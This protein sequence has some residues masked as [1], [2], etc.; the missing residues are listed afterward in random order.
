MQR[1]FGLPLSTLATALLVVL[2]AVLGVVAVLA[3]RNLVFARLAMR[4]V[5]RRRGRSALIVT[6]L[7]LATTIIAAALSTGD[8]VSHAVRSSVLTSLGSTDEM[9]SAKGAKPKAVL[10]FGQ[11]TGVG[12]FDT[13]VAAH[14]RRGLRD[15]SLVDGVAPAI[16][17]P[18]S[19]QDLTSRQTEPTVT[20]FASDPASLQGFGAIRGLDGTAVSLADLRANEVF[21]NARS[22]TKFGAR[23]GDRLTVFAA[24]T[25][26]DATVRAVVRYH[27]AGTDGPAVLM[28]LARAQEIFGQGGR[29]NHVLISNRGDEVSG[30]ANTDAVRALVRPLIARSGLEVDPTKQDGLDAADAQGAAFLSLFT[31]FGTFS[32]SA[33]ILLIFLIFVMLAA[34]RRTEM[35]IARAVGTRRGHLVE[36]FVFEGLAYDLAAAAVGAAL[37]LAVAYAMVTAID[38]ALAATSSIELSFSVVP[39]SVVIAYTLGVVLTLAVVAVSAWRVS[40]LNIVA[41]VRNLPAV[42]LARGGRR[43]RRGGIALAALG[44]IFTMAGVSGKQATPLMLGLSLVVIGCASIAR[45]F[46]VSTRAAYTTAGITVVTLMLLPFHYYGSLVPG[47]QMDFS[48]WIVAGLLV[49]LGAVWV[50]SYNDTIVLGGLVTVLGR[51]RRLAPILKTSVAY[52]LRERFR[53]GAILAMFTLVVFTLV[54]GAT[55][56]NAFS[57][58]GNDTVEFGGGFDVQAMV[59]PVNPITDMRAAIASSPALRASD[60]PVIGAQSYLPVEARQDGDSTFADYQVRGLDDAYLKSTRFGLASMAQGYGS[61]RDVW[62]ALK[63]EPG[64]AVVDPFVVPHR[65][66]W[67]FAVLPDFQLS[68]L[69]AEDPHFAPIGVTVRDPQTGISRHLTVI[70]VLKDTASYAMG[71]I[72]TSQAALTSFGDRVQPSIYYF[73][74]ASGID[75]TQAAHRLESAFLDH[76]LE[77]NSIRKLLA[78]IMD[79]SNAYQTIILGFL[80]L[81]LVVGVAALGVISAR[82]VVERRQHIGVLRAI[83]F[84]RSMVQASFVLEASFLALT[85]IVLGSALG[86]AVAFNVISDASRSASWAGI[87]FDVPWLTLAGIFAA[88]Y[89]VAVAT[90]LLPARRASRIQPATALRYQ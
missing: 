70:G 81:G 9:V 62:R 42:A 11:A 54:V 27:G 63:R 29:I 4:N 22:Q 82:A 30:A 5:A 35:G 41:A 21:V 10:A 78:D 66:N 8:T 39:R 68:G 13:S 73:T 69:H 80:G 77:A 16:I 60:Y 28:P 85:S 57:S 48:T 45:S 58:A 37:G 56:S 86:L 2:A 36:G 26:V 38:S 7:M 15:E 51:V 65:N 55:T 44:G 49:V 79:V 47:I 89:F 32:I 20:L 43:A 6:G 75:A 18:I 1:L 87:R 50:L 12:Y 14:L 71:G 90:A 74:V 53:T 83:G 76:G 67:N 64:L 19:V 3:A 52:P 84:Q 46:G 72:L 25:P 59:S 17:E 40:K 23:A 31:T 33:G 34:E 24:G 88:V 61:A